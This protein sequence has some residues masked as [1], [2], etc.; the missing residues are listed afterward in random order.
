MRKLT[1]SF[2]VARQ[3][4]FR[5]LGPIVEAAVALG[6]WAVRV[7]V[8][9]P[10]RGPK[11]IYN[12]SAETIPHGLRGRVEV[13]TTASA[14]HFAEALD[15]SDAVIAILGRGAT[16]GAEKGRVSCPIWCL[17]FDAFHS[18][19]PSH[20]FADADIVF[21]PSP[22]WV[23][24]ADDWGAGP[25]TELKARGRFVGYAR[26]DVLAMFPDTALRRRFGIVDDRPIVLFVPD[27]MRLTPDDNWV[28]PWF[29]HLWCENHVGRR[30]HAAVRSVRSVGAIRDA[31][32]RGLSESAM[33]RALRAF[34]DRNGAQL[35]M[36][37]RKAKNWDGGKGYTDL[38]MAIADH[39]IEES[40]HYPQTLPLLC[41][42]ADLVVCAYPSDTVFDAAAAGTPY[43]GIRLPDIAFQDT[44]HARKRLD[45]Y[46]RQQVGFPGVS[47]SMPAANFV[48]RFP[49]MRLTDFAVDAA[50]RDD[51]VARLLGPI[52]GRVAVRILAQ[53]EEGVA[54]NRP[55]TA[56]AET[57][58]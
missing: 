23:Q 32:D 37:P 58:W 4:Y 3:P 7:V 17:V 51:Y 13:I 48:R 11:A 44:P 27:S 57:R 19:M 18:V 34:C 10:D 25:A 28:S 52:D 55:P 26:T 12:I 36:Q 46:D 40:E 53:V 31:F 8:A 2:P 47:W 54:S 16:L 6:A 9:P 30:L 29:L 14:R 5:T 33:L 39:A 43:V 42:A 15:A 21:W 41:K 50:A 38:E 35:V 24:V 49:H 1:L 20:G 45:F 22:F 56:M